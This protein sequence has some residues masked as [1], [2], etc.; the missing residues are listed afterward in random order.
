MD[1]IFWV[2]DWLRDN[3]I[4][5]QSK[6]TAALSQSTAI[7]SLRERARRYANRREQHH[8]K[9]KQKILAGTGIDF[10][11]GETTCPSPV[12]MRRQV[13]ELFNHVWHYFDR[14]VVADIFTPNLLEAPEI[15][16]QELVQILVTHL[17]PL[18]Y[19]QELGAEHLLEFSPKI[20]C[21]DHWENHARE[22]G[23]GEA[24]RLRDSLTRKVQE[25]G[26]F[27][28]EKDYLGELGY[29]ISLPGT[30]TTTGIPLSRFP[31]HTE[32]QLRSVLASLVFQE[33]FKALTF[34]VTSAHQLKV[35]LGS[36][37]GMHEEFLSS[38][39]PATLADVIF[40]LE[41]PGSGWSFNQGSHQA[42]GR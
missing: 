34:D 3:G 31:D 6:A 42:Q 28:Y 35:P 18:F 19:V 33:N 17:P 16:Q 10:V 9:A 12:C 7:E 13:D 37:I 36:V 4:T 5:S 40:R 30:D 27:F 24:L 39:A 25:R 8:S 26:E 21:E 15:S 11:G 1:H 29:W 14:V 20:A 2:F 41:T 38:S 22:E 23:L 32:E